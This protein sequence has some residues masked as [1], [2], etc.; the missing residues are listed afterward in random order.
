MATAYHT[1]HEAEIGT[2]PLHIIGCPHGRMSVQVIAT[3]DA[4]YTVEHTIS[5]NDEAWL[6]NV[7]LETVSGTRDS[8]YMFPVAGVRLVIH[9][10]TT[11][12]VCLHLLC[13]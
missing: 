8:N 12:T 10:I 5:L 4:N 6:P 9:S 13:V 2:Y 11:G 7:S 1:E 3:G